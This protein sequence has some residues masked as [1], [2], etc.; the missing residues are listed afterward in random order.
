MLEQK[1]NQHTLGNPQVFKGLGHGGIGVDKRGQDLRFH[2]VEIQEMLG[3]VTP[4]F[5][6]PEQGRSQLLGLQDS[7][8]NYTLR[9]VH[10]RVTFMNLTIT[11]F[12]R[13]NRTR[14]TAVAGLGPRKGMAAAAEKGIVCTSG[15]NRAAPGSI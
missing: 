11:S 9:Q 2:Q 6:L 4:G 3:Q 1:L 15:Q 13:L 7:S 5:F 8:F 10:V 12:S 14:I